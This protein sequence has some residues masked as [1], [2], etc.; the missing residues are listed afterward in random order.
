MFKRIDLILVFKFGFID[1]MSY[2]DLS[3]SG[4]GGLGNFLFSVSLYHDLL[5]DGGLLQG[6]CARFLISITGCRT[7]VIVN[8]LIDDFFI[9]LVLS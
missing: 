3:G 8:L 6:F 4:L 7:F 2:F 1:G 5:K 9:I